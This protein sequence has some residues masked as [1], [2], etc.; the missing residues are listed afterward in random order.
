MKQFI[1]FFAAIVLWFLAETAAQAQSRDDLES[2]LVA[3]LAN[4]TLKGSWI[5]VNQGATGN[6]KSDSYHIIGAR[7]IEGD[8][9]QIMTK[10]KYQGREIE[11]PFSVIVKWAGDTA[12]MILNDVQAGQGKSYSA[13][14]LFHNDR[15]AGSWWGKDTAGGLLSGVITRN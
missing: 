13:R 4:A 7:K 1:F 11:V 9:W 10:T 2:G 14:V 5:P 8:Q 3:M 6:E 12:V 15:Y